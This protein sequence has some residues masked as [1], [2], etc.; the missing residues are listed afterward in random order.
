MKIGWLRKKNKISLRLQLITELH[1]IFCSDLNN[2]LNSYDV[3]KWVKCLP[4][5]F[6]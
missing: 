6:K 3:D 4:L 5:L 2:Q 1:L